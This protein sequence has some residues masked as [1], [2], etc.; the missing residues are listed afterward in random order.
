M[1]Q[2]RK[3]LPVFFS[4]FF[5]VVFN[6]V[7]AE[8]D[9]EASVE[10]A[11]KN[12]VG[13]ELPKEASYLVGNERVVLYVEDK[14]WVLNGITKDNHVESVGKGELEN[15]TL[16]VY[17]TSTTLIEILNS[18]NQLNS[19]IQAEKGGKIRIDPVGVKRTVKFSIASLLSRFLKSDQPAQQLQDQKSQRKLRQANPNPNLLREESVKRRLSSDN[20]RPLLELKPQELEPAFIV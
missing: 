1:I 9:L 14:E 20:P 3:V 10:W 15:P 13:A 16:K 4:I 5:L 17:T 19:F 2:K 12:L 11:Q 18:E 6:L 7:S 8:I